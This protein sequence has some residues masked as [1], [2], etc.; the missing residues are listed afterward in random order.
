M[1]DCGTTYSV[2]KAELYEDDASIR[3]LA[4]AVRGRVARHTLQHPVD[5]EVIVRA[6]EVITPEQARRVA[7]LGLENLLVRSPATCRPPAGVCQLCYG[8]DPATG[9]L[10]ELGAAV[11]VVA[12]QAVADPGASLTMRT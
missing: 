3:G 11:G 10:V 4:E 2:C 9:R 6:N 12:A 1:P 8:A 5:D 7:A